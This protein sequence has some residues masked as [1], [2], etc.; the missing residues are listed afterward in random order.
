MRYFHDEFRESSYI[1]VYNLP[2]TVYEP[3]LSR[4]FSQFGEVVDVFIP[5]ELPSKKTKGVAFICYE[6]QRSTDLAVDNFNGIS[7]EGATLRVEHLKRF[8]VPQDYK[9]IGKDQELEEKYYFVSGPDGRGYGNERKLSKQEKEFINL[10]KKRIE[11]NQNDEETEKSKEVLERERESHKKKVKERIYVEKEG[12][13][14]VHD[15]AIL[16]LE[17]KNL[18]QAK[19][20]LK[21]IEKLKQELKAKL[22]K[23]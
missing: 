22:E 23:K 15:K 16:K 4:V 11:S 18:S 6:D 13:S 20:R 17:N 1:A 7:F 19:E 9:R 8:E 12:W 2:S 21:E 14:N 5:R 3:D 10:Q